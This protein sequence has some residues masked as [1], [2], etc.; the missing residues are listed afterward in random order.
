[1][2]KR[3]LIL[4][5][6]LAII[7][8]SILIISSP[9]SK[10]TSSSS[11]TPTP[12]STESISPTSVIPTD[13]KTYEN[14][15]YDFSFKYPSYLH[16]I[17]SISS[18][19]S[20]PS[21]QFQSNDYQT[22]DTGENTTVSRGLSLAYT[23]DYS[24]GC[25]TSEDITKHELNITSIDNHETRR[26]FVSWEGMIFYA[27][28]VFFPKS[29]LNISLNYG[30]NYNKDQVLDIFTQILSTFKFSDN[31][32]II[33]SSITTFYTAVNSYFKSN[34]AIVPEKQFYS[35]QGM[36]DKASWSLDISKVDMEKGLVN[37]VFINQFNME[38]GPGGGDRGGASIV[39]FV[40]DKL[41]C[42]Y[43][44]GY[45]STGGPETW[46]DSNSYSNILCI[47]K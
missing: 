7:F 39:E 19:N 26:Y 10:K 37:N 40:N 31:E 5:S 38:I 41:D 47:E 11:L 16:Q 44:T 15:E 9:S 32:A 21:E 43:S 28:D 22:E 45:N 4:A 42:Y 29:C 1:M 24:L 2:N 46:N 27:A 35:S 23:Y 25:D 34:I 18:S 17:K 33:P 3:N 6:V 13:W 14:K 12:T 30:N 36:I 8:T 20:L